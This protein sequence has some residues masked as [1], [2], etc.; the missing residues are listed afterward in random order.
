MIQPEALKKPER[1][2]WST[3][4]GVEVW[5]MFCACL[6]GDLPTVKRLVE[7]DPSLVRCQHAYRTPI[8]FAVRENRIDVAMFLLDHGADPF[9][10]AVGDSLLEI[11]RDRGY[12]E[13]TALLEARLAETHNASPR[14]EPVAA[15]IRDRDLPRLRSLLDASPELLHAGDGRSN[16]PIHWAVMARQIDV[17]DELLARGANIEA[18][19]F[20]GARPIQLTNGDYTF[21]GW[22]DVP[23]DWPTTPAEVLAHLRAR[24]AYCDIATACHIGDLQRVRELLDQ[25]PSLANRVSA[26]VT[27]YLGS[28][29]P[30]RNAAANGHL[31]IVEAAALARGGSE[32]ARRGHSP[33]RPRALLRRREPAPRD[34]EDPPGAR[35]LPE[36]GGRE[37]RGCPE[38]RD[39]ELRPAHD[40]PAVLVRRRPCPASPGLLTAT[41]RRPRRSSPRTPPWPTIPTRS[42][43]PRAKGTSPSCACCCGTSRTCRSGLRSRAGRSAPG[44]GS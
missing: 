34:R 5:E 42:S 6:A 33:S 37:L 17:I 25:D 39:L 28:G 18:A 24:G 11:C 44:R 35:S 32:P 40:R 20:D 31:E 27:Y 43:T 15:A 22:R 13:M 41:C 38:P 9:G 23:Q 12:G 14:G 26:Y 29:A 36:P 4:S 8:H 3:G 7:R 2:L 21:R 16:Q 1:L 10:L 19:R 30:L